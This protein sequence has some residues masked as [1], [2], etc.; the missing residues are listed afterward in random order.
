M[1]Y[2]ELNFEEHIEVQLLNSGYIK[3]EKELYDKSLCLIPSQ[4]R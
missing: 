1:N 2:T 4:L 3:V